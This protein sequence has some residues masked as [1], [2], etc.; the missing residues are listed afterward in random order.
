VIAGLIAR[1]YYY[2]SWLAVSDAQTMMGPSTGTFR[3]KMFEFGHRSFLRP[4]VDAIMKR[5]VWLFLREPSQW[6]HLLLMMVLLCIFLISI[7]SLQL[8][9]SQPLLEAVS[10]LVVFLFNG[11]LIASI[12]LR[13]VFPSVSLEGEAFWVVRTSPLTLKSLYLHKFAFAFLSLLVLAEFLSIA[14]EGM[15]RQD[16]ALMGLAAISTGCIALALTSMNLGAGTYFASFKEKNPIRVA[17]SQGASVTFLMSMVYLTCV[18]AIL[19]VPLHN[20][21]ERSLL[22]GG[23]SPSWIVLPA[24]VVGILSFLCFLVSSSIGLKSIH[25]DY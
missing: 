24:I 15:L 18:I 20:Y 5:D 13:F 8:R 9:M 2:E 11:F 23:Q 10:F 21:F 1:R 22:F 3:L 14:S 19:I 7:N 16:P 6:L 17:S 12:A 25:R 4:Q